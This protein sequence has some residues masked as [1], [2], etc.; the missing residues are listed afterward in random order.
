MYIWKYTFEPFPS[1]SNGN[2]T[3]KK[4]A[5]NNQEYRIIENIFFLNLKNSRVVTI[6]FLAF[7]SQQVKPISNVLQ[8]SYVATLK[9]QLKFYG[10]EAQKCKSKGISTLDL[11]G[12]KKR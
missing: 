1:A 11:Q 5:L 7:T 8:L 2:V 4:T 6:L 12:R 10:K 3:K 9:A